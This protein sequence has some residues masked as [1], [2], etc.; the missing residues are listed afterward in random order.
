MFNSKFISSKLTLVSTVAIMTVSLLNIQTA[1]GYITP[2]GDSHAVTPIV[3]RPGSQVRPS[4]TPIPRPGNPVRPIPRPTPRPMPRPIPVPGPIYPGPVYP[5]P[6][7]PGPIY[8]SPG[9]PPPV[10]YTQYKTAYVNRWV[11]SENFYVD[12]LIGYSYSNY[13]IRNIR[14]DVAGGSA[15]TVSL[16][17]NG[18]LIDSKYTS[19][20]DVYLYPGYHGYDFGYDRSPLRIT[21]NGAVYIYKIVFELERR[22]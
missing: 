13:R 17:V 16:F 21:V 20:Y 10:N 4:P 22:Y 1:Y 9:Y 12:S 19:G 5:G 7:Y 11:Y 6:V 14:V 8:P 15:A 2:G 18:Q 3:P